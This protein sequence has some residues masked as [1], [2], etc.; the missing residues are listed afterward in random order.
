V[1][2]GLEINMK[3]T[4]ILAST[5]AVFLTL[6]AYAEDAAT[7]SGE[8]ATKTPAKRAE[9]IVDEQA[10]VIKFVID[11]VEKARIDEIGLHVA[12]DV[13]YTGT[14]ADTNAIAAEPK[15]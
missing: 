9:L 1:V 6:P 8:A 3:R 13:A 14:L 2:S 4:T 7:T 5:L 12:G 10:G 11:G 15:P